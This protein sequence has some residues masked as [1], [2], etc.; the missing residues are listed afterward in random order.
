MLKQL[1]INPHLFTGLE[2]LLITN[3]V[4]DFYVPGYG[5]YRILD[6]FNSY[7]L[8]TGQLD[9]T[10]AKT[11]CG[12]LPSKNSG[13]G[14]IFDFC[15]KAGLT[16]KNEMQ[17]A[18]KQIRNT[19]F[20]AELVEALNNAVILG[21]DVP[22]PHDD[23]EILELLSVAMDNNSR[24]DISGDFL[25]NLKA[26]VD[27]Y[28]FESNQKLC[29]KYGLDE[30]Y[31]APSAG[32]DRNEIFDIIKNENRQRTLNA[33]EIINN[34]RMLSAKMA[35]L[36]IKLARDERENSKP[37]TKKIIGYLK[38]KLPKLFKC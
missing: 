13:K 19:S 36:C 32:L 35:E 3:I 2:K 1:N 31:F 17:N 5:D 4:D 24:M 8:I 21:L 28:F 7:E 11:K 26:Y 22:A 38:G 20:N 27:N 18:S 23:N 25:L 16:L 37:F 6:W 30:M 9:D 12:V 15:E 29:S 10:K 33:P 34:Y 14:L